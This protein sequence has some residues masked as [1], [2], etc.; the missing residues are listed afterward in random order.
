MAT[1]T[2]IE[3]PAMVRFRLGVRTEVA[4]SAVG[5]RLAMTRETLT[6]PVGV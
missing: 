3:L 2:L 1:I 5:R 6:P 4:P